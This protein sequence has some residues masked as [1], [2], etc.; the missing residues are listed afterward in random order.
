MS[1][2][3]HPAAP[4]GGNAEEVLDAVFDFAEH[5]IAQQRIFAKQMLAAATNEQHPA[6]QATEA[7]ASAL[8]RGSTSAGPMGPSHGSSTDAD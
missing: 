5:L 1:S 3:T 6:A 8:M 4:A 7:R 2:R